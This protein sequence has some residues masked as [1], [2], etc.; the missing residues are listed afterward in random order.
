MTDS[1]TGERWTVGFWPPDDWYIARLP[2]DQFSSATGK[3]TE[4]EVRQAVS[5]INDSP[6]LR[7]QVAEL[8]KRLAEATDPKNLN[9]PQMWMAM[10][11]HKEE[12]ARLRSELAAKEET[13]KGLVEA[14]TVPCWCVRTSE[15]ADKAKHDAGCHIRA[16]LSSAQKVEK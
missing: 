6:R 14:M 1:K 12:A 4:A 5:D 16:A 11:E 10:L 9:S 8:E 2:E 15:Q 3:P 13:I 7:E